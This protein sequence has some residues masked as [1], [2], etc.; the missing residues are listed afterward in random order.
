MYTLR[1]PLLEDD[2]FL[3]MVMQVAMLPT[4]QKENPAYKLNLKDEYNPV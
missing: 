2:Y 1:K 3:F 4:K